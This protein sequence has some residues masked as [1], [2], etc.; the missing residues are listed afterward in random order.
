MN[1]LGI[2]ILCFIF[3]PGMNQASFAQDKSDSYFIWKLK[4]KEHKEVYLLG[5]PSF[6]EKDLK[7]IPD[8]IKPVFNGSKTLIFDY[9]LDSLRL[10]YQRLYTEKGFYQNEESLHDHLDE[11]L[12]ENLEKELD[13]LGNPLGHHPRV[14]PWLVAHSFTFSEDQKAGYETHGLQN[15]FLKWA[16]QSHKKI[17][18]LK[19]LPSEQFILSELSEEDQIE[20]LQ[21]RVEN[22]RQNLVQ[23]PEFYKAWQEGNLTK[24]E[25]LLEKKNLPEK[26]E[27]ILQKNQID[28]SQI[29]DVFKIEENILIIMDANRLVGEKSFLKSLEDKGIYPSL[30]RN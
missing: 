2:L 19:N 12:Y 8:K 29:L 24:F 10:E 25:R 30:I 26:F 16:K 17:I 13:F 21:Y 9:H 11:N 1:K 27:L 22:S 5:L 23:K 18:S 3:F 14:K 20:Y 4:T 28:M 7:K 6:S 15:S